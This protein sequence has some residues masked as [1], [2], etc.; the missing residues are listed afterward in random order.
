MSSGREPASSRT[1]SKASKRSMSSRVLGTPGAFFLSFPLSFITT[2]LSDTTTFLPALPLGGEKTEPGGR[3][4]IHPTHAMASMLTKPPTLCSVPSPTKNG[5]IF[6]VPAD[7]LA[8]LKDSSCSMQSAQ[9][10]S[11]PHPHQDASTS[12]LPTTT[13][14]HIPQLAASPTPTP[15]LKFSIVKEMEADSSTHNR[16]TPCSTSLTL[17]SSLTITPD[18]LKLP[19]LTANAPLV[20]TRATHCAQVNRF[21]SHKDSKNSS[22]SLSKTQLSCKATTARS[23]PSSSYARP[24]RKLSSLHTLSLLSSLPTLSVSTL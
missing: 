21:Q 3:E 20:V 7:T 24:K 15:K 12:S 17:S 16:A 19:P 9:I 18:T 2:S 11:F 1:S 23:F 5:F 13:S 4:E 10:A 22:S 8:S 6:P 14:P